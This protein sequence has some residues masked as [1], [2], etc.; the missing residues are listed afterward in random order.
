MRCDFRGIP[1]DNA[2]VE[3]FNTIPKRGDRN[4]DGEFQRAG[5]CEEEI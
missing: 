5:G 1:P 4:G 2:V 3:K